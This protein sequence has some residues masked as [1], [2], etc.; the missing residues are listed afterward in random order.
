MKI[1]TL[2]AFFLA[3]V[4][5]SNG[6]KA[7]G[8]NLIENGDFERGGRR[9]PAGWQLP[10]G[11]T[12]F[13]VNA[14]GR[15]GKCIKI[16]TD[17]LVS[18]FRA[19]EDEMEAAEKAGRKPPPP[20]RRLPTRPPKYDTVAGLDGVH[21]GCHPISIQ[22]GKY[23]LLEADVR[24][25]GTA[26]PKI[27]VK[28]YGTVKSRNLTRERV[29]WKKS[30]NCEGASSEWKTFRM[31]FPRN[32]AIPEKV[33]KLRLYL[34]PFW[35]PAVYYFDNVRLVEITEEDVER[36]GREHDLLERPSSRTRTKTKKTTKS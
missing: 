8:K 9:G 4:S 18:Q 24:V 32:T 26:S 16:N 19:R 21:F 17:V 11:L 22:P 15:K 5:L 7:G 2:S 34:Y 1:G 6:G 10:D 20:P 30:L 14:P 12:S 3:A 27:W 28:G 36:F 31:V 33:S 29:L 23:F 25:E 13:W 35:P